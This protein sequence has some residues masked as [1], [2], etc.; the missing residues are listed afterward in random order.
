MKGSGNNLYLTWTIFGF[1]LLNLIR[2]EFE[3]A[4]NATH[5]EETFDHAPI[6]LTHLYGIRAMAYWRTNQ[7]EK[8]I[9]Y[10]AKS[11]PILKTLPPQLYS[12]LVGE[13]PLAQIIFEAWEQGKTYEIAGFRNKSGFRKSASTIV[14]LLKKFQRTFPFGEPTYLLYRG[15]LYDMQG[16]HKLA[17]KSWQAS[18]EVARKLSM[19]RD[20]ANAL[21]ELGKH[22]S[23][24]T[25][26][27][28]LR[29]ALNIFNSA[30]ALYDSAETEKLLELHSA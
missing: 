5:S 20:E 16:N 24:E 23:G 10:C 3:E 21:R 30:C 4:L 6:N 17:L 2:G 7:K 29:D 25:R 19:P 27:K 11:L 15:W 14:G 12:L 9:Q 8:A 22:S 18:A 13:R 26:R 1:A 28:Y